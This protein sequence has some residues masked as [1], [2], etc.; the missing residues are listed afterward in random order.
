MGAN[1][2]EATELTLVGLPTEVL[3]TVAKFLG[4][5]SG[6]MK[7][8]ADAVAIGHGLCEWS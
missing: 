1:I 4:L 3:V 5:E 7:R 8:L 2:L 6:E